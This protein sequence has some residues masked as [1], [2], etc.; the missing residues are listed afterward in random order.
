MKKIQIISLFMISIFAFPASAYDCSQIVCDCSCP[1]YT[2]HNYAG[3][4]FAI[5]NDNLY[6][7]LRGR[8]I[9]T[10]QNNGE[11]YYIS[12]TEKKLYYLGDYSQALKVMQGLGTGANS[13]TLK[14]VGT[15]Y[16]RL[17]GYDSDKDGLPDD[18][19]SLIGTN[20]GT[21]NTDGDR[22]SDKI[23]I[24]NNYN[25][26]KGD[27]K[28]MLMSNNLKGRIFLQV[29]RKGEAWYMNPLDEKKYLLKTQDDMSNLINKFALGISNYDLGRLLK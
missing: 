4:S 2:C 26:N 1:T 11:T 9:I 14:R 19:E 15:G 3:K 16:G 7:H 28:K 10:P 22:Y 29:D 21:F 18:F 27:G 17:N 6:N 20:I 5:K 12:A 13:E 25:P 8:I 24:D 23:E